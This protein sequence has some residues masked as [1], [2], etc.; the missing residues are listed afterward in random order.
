MPC[1]INT[2]SGPFNA[3]I[4]MSPNII[5]Q[6]IGSP[7]PQQ[8]IPY[9]ILNVLSSSLVASLPDLFNVARETER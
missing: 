5:R 6:P 9:E 7:F 1:L 3:I 8:N 2:D 4:G